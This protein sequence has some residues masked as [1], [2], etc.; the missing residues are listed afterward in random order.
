[1]PGYWFGGGDPSGDRILVATSGFDGTT[2]ET[3]LQYGPAR[4]RADG[5]CC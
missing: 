5:N 1:M 4:P 2:E 3:Y